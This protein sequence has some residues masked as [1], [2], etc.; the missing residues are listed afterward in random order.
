MKI[1]KIKGF[2]LKEATERM[3]EELGGEAVILSTKIYEEGN[4]KIFEITAGIDDGVMPAQKGHDKKEKTNKSGKAVS[5]KNFE[6]ELKKLTEK[7]YQIN[8]EKKSE[9]SLAVKDEDL[10]EAIKDIEQLLIQREV[11][12]SLVRTIITDLKSNMDFLT[13]E[14]LDEQ[15]FTIISSMIV[16]GGF[17][18]EKGKGPKIITLVGPTGVGKTT[19]IA[20]LALI[21]KIIHK[22]DVGLI[23]IDTYRLGAIDQLKIFAEVS[24]IDF[25]VAYEPADVKNSLKKFRKKDLIFIDTVGR[26]QKNSKLLND[27]KKFLEPAQSD[28]VYLVMSAT[29]ATRTLVDVANKFKI[30]KYNGFVFTKLDEAVTFGNILNIA[31]RYDIPI[32]YL[33]NGQV[34][35]DDIIAADADFIANLVISGKLNG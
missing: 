21:S 31:A 23:S 9:N 3:K 14:Q 13:K 18:V 30:F 8:R 27:I 32:K 11:D 5:S 12:T 35:P 28:E 6:S 29:S 34:I 25:E 10:D 19:C 24:N 33:T 16:T 4:R 20:K 26:S 17:N 1:K 2:S 15:L 7:I 22:L